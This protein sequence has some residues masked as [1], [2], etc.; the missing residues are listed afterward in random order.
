[1][2][3]VIALPILVTLIFLTSCKKETDITQPILNPVLNSSLKDG[4]FPNPVSGCTDSTA[5]NY[6]P[7]ADA[8]DG[9]CL[10]PFPCVGDSL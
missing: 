3:K 10:Y 5:Y 7:L 6:D 9:S 1:M 2:K 8:D 4:K